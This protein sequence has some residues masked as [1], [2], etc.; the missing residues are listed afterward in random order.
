MRMT[1][2]MASHELSAPRTGLSLIRHSAR[3]W[4]GV[5]LLGQWAFMSYLV[6][7][8]VRAILVGHPEHWNRRH[9]DLKF[10]VPGDHAWNLYFGA[11]VVL[12]AVIAFGATLQM[13]PS[14]RERFRGFHRWNGRTFVVMAMG[15]AVTGLW[16]TLVRGVDLGGP[17][18]RVALTIDAVLILVFATIAWR[19]A[20]ARRFVEHRRWALRL[21]MV[22]NGVWFLRLGVFSWNLMTGGVGMT[23]KF[24][25]P[26]DIAMSFA[27]FLLPL[28]ILE[29]YLSASQ[30]RSPAARNAAAIAVLAG[31]AVMALGIFAL[32]RGELRFLLRA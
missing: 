4:W 10:F 28:V 22:A 18:G 17:G 31:T 20:R 8:Y 2:T 30:S 29:A 24:D 14:L 21:F 6:G 15:G 32:S 25:G 16:M 12:A 19:R 3:V 5:T 11:H 7:F 9:A 23:D 1:T 27:S 26:T 13:V